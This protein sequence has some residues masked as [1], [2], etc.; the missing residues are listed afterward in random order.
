MDLCENF[1]TDV[2]VDK[3]E[4]INFESHPPPDPDPGIFKRIFQHY[5]IW[6]ISLERVIGFS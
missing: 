1:T 3:E 4:L 2:P 5:T 6:L